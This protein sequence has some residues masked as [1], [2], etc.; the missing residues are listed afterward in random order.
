MRTADTNW[1]T[2]HRYSRDGLEFARVANLADAVFAIALTLLVLGLDVG[3][4]RSVELGDALWAQLPNLVAF[5]LGF[6]LVANIWWQ[7]HKFFARLSHLDAGLVAITLGLLGL[8]ALVP[9]PTGLLGAHPTSEPTAFLFIT[10]FTTLTLVFTIGVRHAYRR[11]LWRLQPDKVTY[12]WVMAGFGVTLAVMLIAIATAFV[13][14]VLALLVL[15][16]SN[17]PER[18]LARRAPR[19]YRE[20][21]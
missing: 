13:A 14:P 4:V 5:V 18:V 2:N 17:I 15:A 9:F 1:S 12:R 20:W 8:V 11:Q 19:S 10:L 21:A 6:A 3:T 16:S 7:H